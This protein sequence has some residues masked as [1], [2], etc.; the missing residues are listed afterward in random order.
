M[1]QKE[2]IA[3]YRERARKARQLA[4][5]TT[6]RNQRE[7]YLRSAATWEEEAAKIEHVERMRT[8]N[9]AAAAARSAARERPDGKNQD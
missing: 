4:Q 2:K 9:E 7:A 3:E 6:V 5:E 8:K 1:N